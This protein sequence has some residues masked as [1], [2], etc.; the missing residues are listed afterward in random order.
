MDVAQLVIHLGGGAADREAVYTELF[1]LE[2]EHYELTFAEPSYRCKEIRDIAVACT[3][4]LCGVLTR[5]IAEVS[6]KEYHRASQLLVALGGVDPGRVGA[7]TIRLDIPPDQRAWK[8]ETA[9]RAIMDS[10]GSALGVVRAKNRHTLTVEDALTI[11]E[12][13]TRDIVPVTNH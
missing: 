2:A 5:P 6:V 9:F 8:E 10:Q 11:G 12:A 3:I 4:P 13:V 7:E 1:A